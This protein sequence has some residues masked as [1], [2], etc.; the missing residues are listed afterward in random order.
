MNM[1]MM[2][3]TYNHTQDKID[4]VYMYV[5]SSNLSLEVKTYLSLFIIASQ[6]SSAKMMTLYWLF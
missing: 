2:V 6:I 3:I 4:I 1:L 5:A